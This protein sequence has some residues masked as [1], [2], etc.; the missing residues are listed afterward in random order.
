MHIQLQILIFYSWTALS[1]PVVVTSG[2]LVMFVSL[3]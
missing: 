1:L 3:V 2:I